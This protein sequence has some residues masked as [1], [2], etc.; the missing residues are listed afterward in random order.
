MVGRETDD[1]GI[2]MN[3]GRKG[4]VDRRN[5]CLPGGWEGKK[6]KE[7]SSHQESNLGWRNQNPQ[8]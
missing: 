1:E 7:I 4:A 8:S 6:A 3:N 2:T 5:D